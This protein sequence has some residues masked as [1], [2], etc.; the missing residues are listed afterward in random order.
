V[1]IFVLGISGVDCHDV[2]PQMER[3]WDFKISDTGGDCHGEHIDK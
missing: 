3:N 2:G 1:K